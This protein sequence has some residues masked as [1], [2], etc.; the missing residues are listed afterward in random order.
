MYEVDLVG[1][2]GD[3]LREFHIKLVFRHLHG[4]V[5]SLDGPLEEIEIP[6]FGADH[7]LPVPLVDIN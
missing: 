3:N 1:K 6:V 2:L 5:D 4:L 7:F